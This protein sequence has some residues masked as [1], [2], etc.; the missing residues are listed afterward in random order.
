MQQLSEKVGFGSRI[1]PGIAVVPLQETD[2]DDDRVIC[3]GYNGRAILP[4]FAGGIS[5]PFVGIQVLRRI[6]EV[7]TFRGET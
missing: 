4:D 7:L 1:A 2:F 6:L 5:T 3:V